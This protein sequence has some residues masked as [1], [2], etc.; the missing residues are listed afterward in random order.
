MAKIWTV[1]GVFFVVLACSTKTVEGTDKGG[2]ADTDTDTDTDTDSDYERVPQCARSCNTAL[3]CDF[4]SK[5]YDLDNHNCISGAC[6][7]T[8][9]NTDVECDDHSPGSVCTTSPFGPD[10]C[11]MGCSTVSDCDLGSA[12]YDADNFD[13]VS[14]ACVYSGCNSTAE[15]LTVHFEG[16]VC[17][18][19]PASGIDNCVM[20]CSTT[21]DCDLGFS[22]YGSENHECIN[23][24]CVYSGCNTD[25]ECDDFMAGYVCH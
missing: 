7:W 1:T 16:T 25:E 13:C 15:C 24:G 21:V 14:G 5:P 22:S 9:C 23:G 2:D 6:E 8:G 3:D 18:E 12:P 17:A 4:D 10:Y 19:D 11:T 20:G